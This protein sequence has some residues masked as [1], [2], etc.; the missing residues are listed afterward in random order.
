MFRHHFPLFQDQPGLAY[1][2]NAS[3]T[4]KPR[5]VIDAVS[6]H[7]AG[8]NAN[9]HRGS[10]S[11]SEDAERLYDASKLAA[12]RLLNCD[13]HE[14]VYAYNATACSNYVSRTL[15]YNG[16]LKAGDAVIVSV[17]EHHANLVPWFQL[18]DRIG[19]EVR[20]V[21]LTPDYGLDMADF[22]AKYDDKVKAVALTYC[23]NV[24]GAVFDLPAVSKLLRDDTWF[25]VDASQAVP[26][27]AVDVRALDCDF[28]YFSAHKMMAQTGLGVLYGKKEHLK[29]LLP[30]WGGGGSI[31]W[32]RE[33]GFSFAGLPFR[34]E[35]GTPNIAGAV[36]L[37]AALEFFESVGSYP[38]WRSHEDGLVR[39]MLDGFA[40]LES[41]GVRLIGPKAPEGRV[42]VFSFTVGDRH[43]RD[44]ADE[45]AAK[46][47]CV[48]AGHHCAQP[49]HERLGIDATCRAS[50]YL[51]NDA[52]DVEKFLAAL[53][54]AAR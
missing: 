37:L 25:I 4:Q 24:T 8:S 32:V 19:V 36:S 45:L 46:G 21:G 40:R 29:E 9:I 54:E 28:L 43:V 48:R 38:A 31:N 11:L 30:A 50:L 10:Y 18:R 13:R 35:P 15:A 44:V 20:F 51:H 41:R 3:T 47:V 52:A 2:D 6:A 14:V 27:F 49:L 7:L 26:N 22:A 34:W 12:A 33:D 16:C 53:G 23:S 42:G 5:Q 17:A 39:T 1:L